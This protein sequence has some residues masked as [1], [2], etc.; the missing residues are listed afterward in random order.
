MASR[1]WEL[2]LLWSFRTRRLDPEHRLPAELPFADVA[3]HLSPNGTI[4]LG[5]RGNRPFEG[6]G[7]LGS[8]DAVWSIGRLQRCNSGATAQKR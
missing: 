8:A 6:R 3:L 4:R 2:V 5:V 1:Q 7:V